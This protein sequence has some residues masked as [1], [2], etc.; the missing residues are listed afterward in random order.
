MK[1]QYTAEFPLTNDAASGVP[2]VSLT[3]I[4]IRRRPCAEVQRIQSDFPFLVAAYFLTP[5][6]G[7]E[8]RNMGSLAWAPDRHLSTMHG[9]LSAGQF[10]QLAGEPIEQF[11]QL[12]K[13]HSFDVPVSLFDLTVQIGQVG[14]VLV[15]ESD[16][17]YVGLL[18]EAVNRCKGM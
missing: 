6:L 10:R 17:S 12:E 11:M 18:C 4:R 7:S 9:V 5:Y 2:S 1:S 13:L 8:N 16:C 15:Q 3:A 14:Q